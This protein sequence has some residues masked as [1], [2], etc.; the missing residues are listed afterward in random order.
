MRRLFFSAV[1][2]ALALTLAASAQ[3]VGPNVNTMSGTD[4]KTGDAFLQRQNE[5]AVAISTRNA[6]HVM[7][8][9]NDYRTVDIAL[10]VTEPDAAVFAR[11]GQKPRRE[12]ALTREAVRAQTPA[13]AWIGLAFSRDRGR[14]FYNALLPGYPQDPTTVGR[15]S[16]VY[17]DNAATD[18]ILVTG[19][20]GRVYL[21]A[22][23]FDRGGISRISSTRF[24]DRNNVEGGEPFYFD[25]TK[26]IDQ[27]SMSSKGRFGDKPS[28]AAYAG[29]SSAVFSTSGVSKKKKQIVVVPGCER[30]YTAYT[31]F[32]GNDSNGN[33]RSSIYAA[34]SA[35][36]GESWSNPVKV[37]GPYSVNGVNYPGTRNQGTT[38][39]VDP[40]TGE[41]YI[42]WRTYS[43]SG[44]AYVTS[45]DGG[46]TFSAPRSI[47]SEPIFPFDQRLLKTTDGSNVM[48][49]RS[50]AYPSLTIYDGKAIVT[51]S[52][53]IDLATGASS[54]TG[55]PRAVVT[56]GTKS[57][58]GSMT[59]STRSAVDVQDTGAAGPHQRCEQVLTPNSPTPVVECR[60][61]GAQLMPYVAARD[62]Q[63]AVVYYEARSDAQAPGGIVPAT[64]F[65]SGMQ[66]Q[67]DVRGALV[68]PVTGVTTTSFQISRYQ[69]DSATGRIKHNPNVPAEL[70]PRVNY[71]NF[72]M[73]LGGIAPF[74][75]DYIHAIPLRPDGSGA[76]FRVAFTSNET[77]DPPAALDFTQYDKPQQGVLSSCNPGSRN[78]TVMTAEIGTDLVVGSPGTF[79]QLVNAQNLAVQRAFAVY[80]ENHTAGFRAFRLTVAPT[81]GVQASFE[82]F[83][84]PV[85]SVDVE[86]LASSSITR[87]V[88]L[89]GAVAT[90]SAVVNVVE[91]PLVD[92]ANQLIG[93]QP[94]GLTASLT[95]NGDATNPFVG[96]TGGN[97]GLADT[98]THTP[99]LATP[100]LGT[101]Q[102]GTP[103][104]GT[105][106]LGSPQLGTPQLGTPQLGTPQLS[107][108]Q[109]GTPGL[110]D[111]TYTDILYKVKNA[112][113]TA[114][115]YNALVSLANAPHLTTSGHTFQVFVFR[116][117]RTA[118]VKG[119]AIGLSQQDQVVYMTPQLGT[120]QLGTP[121][122]GTPQIGT[123]QLG[124][125]QL[126]TPQLGTPQLGTP[127]LGTPQLASASFTVA[128]ADPTPTEHDGTE[129]GHQEDDELWLGV[130]ITHPT[131]ADGLAH[132]NSAAF[133]AELANAFAL[134]VEAQAANTG[135]TEPD[136]S[137]YGPDLRVLGTPSATPSIVQPADVVTLFPWTL[138]NAGNQTSNAPDGNVSTNI[139]LSTDPIITSADMLLSDPYVTANG[140]LGAGQSVAFAAP[141]ITVPNVAPGT[142]YIGIL[143]DSG[144]EAAESLEDNNAAVVPI[145]VVAPL[146]ID[147]GT[148]PGPFPL[149]AGVFDSS[150]ATPIV[151][152]GGVGAYTWTI[153]GGA[154][155]LGLSFTS[156]TPS[157]SVTGTPAKVGSGFFTVTL[158]DTAGH[159]VSRSFSITI[160][161]PANPSLRFTLNPTTSHAGK[162]LGLTATPEVQ[163]YYVRPVDSAEVGIPGVTVSVALSTNPTGSSLLGTTSGTTGPGGTV[164]FGNAWI[165]YTGATATPGS[166]AAAAGYVLS[167]TSTGLT[168]ATSS[169][170]TI[171]AKRV[172]IYPDSFVE[173]HPD[174]TGETP[175]ERTIAQAQGYTT[176]IPTSA[177]WSAL[178]TNDFRQYNA[179]VIPDSNHHHNPIG[180]SA[181]GL[182]RAENTRA[183]W[184]PAVAGPKVIIG[185]DPIY[186]HDLAGPPL[187]IRNAINFASSSPD[188]GLF[189]ALSTAYVGATSANVVL[190]DQ[191]GTFKATG[192]E[193][194][195]A[196]VVLSG[197]PTMVDLTD[198]TLSGWGS[199]VHSWFDVYPASWTVVAVEGT[200]GSTRVYIIADR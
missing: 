72:P 71:A 104:I 128:P 46:L 158:A 73:Y 197:H 92:A 130:R 146:A 126:G 12:G 122:L 78:S 37:S 194:S 97:P 161:L 199:S 145:T 137:F 18:P 34:V 17:G 59:W 3:Q 180:A 178:T 159:T 117:H 57:A 82:Q 173:N 44:M 196:H 200:A 135:N 102:L 15:S 98:E 149:P 116:V 171:L 121:Q 141:Q 94:R 192:L 142:Y 64:G 77:V 182:T 45:T 151:G 21:I 43:P 103:Q 5:P 4:P 6:D 61:T 62:G 38:T 2:G 120:P 166:A 13:E 54:A 109:L 39:A 79:K 157:A 93:A 55:A 88:Y 95:L 10:D 187:L 89:T 123:P 111:P 74:I 191:F 26:Q 181:E 86:I 147:T 164:K 68:D 29:S 189:A 112:G 170:F 7:L 148:G 84:A 124:T 51:W 58:G 87:T 127:Q 134:A 69:I 132:N 27:G 80:V 193:S 195:A 175:N 140:A 63:V 90:G 153:T 119:C 131:E 47:V 150:Y 163:A 152:S 81:S 118:S 183:T 65:I 49:F 8:A 32:E 19:Q 91:I 186:H 67:V 53:R 35:S 99:Q 114:S 101:P 20:N 24:T 40:D 28:A 50:N 154:L 25:F 41:V 129:H 133:Y 165:D 155:P 176:V 110:G 66:R 108:P 198:A 107:T 136:G 105:P 1:A 70:G 100:Q 139:Y 125:P 169:S 113:N 106:Q 188:T 168:S 184:S 36:C 31:V 85:T 76:G 185:T 160:G 14:T 9:F 30:L 115:G 190:L 22:L 56:V 33:F 16:P 156:G 138:T 52:E 144:N 96:G 179:V 23:T 42:A 60:A 162:K 143:A 174:G 11:A 177:A 48:T 172:L 167:A 75:G 83:G